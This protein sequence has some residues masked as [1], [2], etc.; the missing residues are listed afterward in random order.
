MQIAPRLAEIALMTAMVGVLLSFCAVTLYANWETV[1][2]G[3]W[4]P[5]Y[6]FTGQRLWIA[7]MGTQ[8]QLVR[9]PAAVL[10]HHTLPSFVLSRAMIAGCCL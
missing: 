5:S 3:Y 9:P 4:D 6:P 1:S 8:L 10:E 7:G 2:P